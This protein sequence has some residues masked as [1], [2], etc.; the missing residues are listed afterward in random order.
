[1]SQTSVAVGG[2]TDANERVSRSRAHLHGMKHSHA[3][4]AS[5]I[6]LELTGIPFEP[7]DLFPGLHGVIVRAKGFAAWTVPALEIDGRKVQGTLAIARELD[8]LAPRRDSIR[9]T[10]SVVA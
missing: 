9:A 1:M 5:R 10:A 7:H 6:A 4:L 3:V 2:S 8:R